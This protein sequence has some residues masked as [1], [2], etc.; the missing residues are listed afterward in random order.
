LV[1]EVPEVQGFKKLVFLD[2]FFGV[3]HPPSLPPSRGDGISV[4][5]DGEQ[6][7]N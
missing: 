1:Q 7:L 4:P 3:I 6:G 2:I 5:E